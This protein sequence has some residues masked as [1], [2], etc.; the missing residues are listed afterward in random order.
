M[1]KKLTKFGNSKAL[2]LDKTILALM[3]LNE[4]SFVKIEIHGNV[5]TI[6]PSDPTPK[7]QM[8]HAMSETVDNLTLE[9]DNNKEDLHPALDSLSPKEAK[10]LRKHSLEKAKSLLSHVEKISEDEI[11]QFDLFKHYF[12]GSKHAT[13]YNDMVNHPAYSQ[14]LKLIAKEQASFETPHLSEDDHF[15]NDLHMSNKLMDFWQKHD[16]E[17]YKRLLDQQ[18][19]LANLANSND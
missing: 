8:V 16:E 18:N 4:D 2:I 5:L 15:K 17:I 10:I 7:E 6:T 3:G 9:H 1:I 11:E 13:L 14:Y 19:E 12:K